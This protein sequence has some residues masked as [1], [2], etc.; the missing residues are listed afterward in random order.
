MRTAQQLA[1][2]KRRASRVSGCL[3]A[4]KER[5]KAEKGAKGEKGAHPRL[6]EVMNRDR[7]LA[8]KMN[9]DHGD[10]SG[11]YNELQQRDAAIR[12]QTRADMKKNGGHLTKAEQM[13]MQ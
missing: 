4:P 5:A 8:G 1:Y 7:H 3:E 13:Q 9:K 2:C 10:L 6:T 11:H 12:A